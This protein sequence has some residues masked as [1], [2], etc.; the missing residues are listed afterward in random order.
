MKKYIFGI[1]AVTMAVGFSAFT[2]KKGH[3][4][5]SQ[6]VY[7]ADGATFQRIE[8][9]VNAGTDINKSL[10]K[11]PNYSSA[12]QN[13]QFRTVSNWS[14]TANTGTVQTSADASTYVMSL[15]IANFDTNTDS[16][17]GDGISIQQA[18]DKLHADYKAGSGTFPAEG[19]TVSVE[20]DSDPLT[21]AVTVTVH[22]AINSH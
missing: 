18:I 3:R 1:L 11:D 13:T 2:T 12:P 7:Y 10:D 16:N 19:G 15:E 9:N 17:D 5:T 14:T 8:F 22:R 4:V 21:P 20:T 6:T